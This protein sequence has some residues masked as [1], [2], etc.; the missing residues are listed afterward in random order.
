VRKS[1]KRV[2][3]LHRAN[4]RAR[5]VL[6]GCHAEL[7]PEAVAELA[8]VDLVIGNLEK[9]ALVALVTAL[10][11]AE[12]PAPALDPDSEPAFASGRTRAFVKVQDGCG[13]RCSF[14]IVTVARGEERSHPIDAVCD[15][16]NALHA[17]GHVEA[18]ITGVHL[19]GY[20]RDRGSSL[21]A[22]LEA[23]LSRTR[24]PW[25]RLGSLEPWDLDADFFDLWTDDRL[26]PHLH[27]PLQSGSDSV[28]RRMARRCDTR[29]YRALAQRA[30]QAGIA[31]TTDV[32]VGFPGE[33][34]AEFLDTHRFVQE[35]QF[36][37]AHLFTYS[38]RQ[39]TAA[40]RMRGQVGAEVKR[41]RRQ[42]LHDVCQ[43]TRSAALRARV[44][45]RQL[46]HWEGQGQAVEGGVRWRGYT[47]AYHRV[48]STLT[49]AIDL[50][51]R[52]TPVQ[53]HAA[54]DQHLIALPAP[55]TGAS[56]NRP[57]VR[58]AP[59]PPSARARTTDR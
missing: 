52:I 55:I 31:L 49:A 45:R 48:E 29:S 42:A 24:I 26:C 54:T 22:L 35:M 6:T 7:E 46:V 37:D 21:R 40:A 8:G 18:V 33:T 44:G 9:E 3:A 50:H 43:A 15:S 19:G 16:L 59:S 10:D 5:L 17:E 27:L 11:P 20:G 51:N 4:P 57:L 36:D 13:N 34:E 58:H 41:H 28:L 23:I 53:I 2:R 1:R 14:C 47:R 38:P 39:G 30:R 56:A 12:M 25:I 32:I